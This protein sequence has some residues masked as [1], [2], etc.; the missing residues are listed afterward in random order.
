MA[1]PKETDP[2]EIPMPSQEGA[3]S[4]ADAWNQVAHIP[5]FEELQ[6]TLVGTDTDS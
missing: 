5:T 1:D 4:D 6:E 2:F 3:I